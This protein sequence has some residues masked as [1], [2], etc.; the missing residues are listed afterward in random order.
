MSLEPGLS[1]KSDGLLALQGFNAFHQRCDRTMTLLDNGIFFGR[2]AILGESLLDPVQLRSLDREPFFLQSARI[3]TLLTAVQ[4]AVRQT[5]NH[6]FSLFSHSYTLTCSASPHLH[7]FAAM[8]F[9]LETAR[10]ARSGYFARSFSSLT[11]SGIIEVRESLLKPKNMENFLERVSQIRYQWPVSHS[12]RHVARTIW[13][14]HLAHV[15]S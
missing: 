3:A 13:L 2:I 12:V 15:T 11:A 14:H 1:V 8:G 7:G 6:I 5:Y 4:A 10:R 9:L